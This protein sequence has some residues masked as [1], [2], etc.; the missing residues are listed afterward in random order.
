MVR[1][2]KGECL[3]SIS[4]GTICRL[5]E[6]ACIC[7][8][9][10]LSLGF[11]YGTSSA[12][13]NDTTAGV[14][15]AR[16]EGNDSLLVSVPYNGD[17][18]QNNTVT[19][20]WKLCPDPSYPPANT[21][22]LPHASSPYAVSIPGLSANT[23]YTVQV[24]YL[25]GVVS[26]TNP[27]TLKLNT[28]WDNTM[29]H[30]VNRFPSSAKWGGD[31]GT[32][33]GQYGIIDCET[34]HTR[35]TS[36]IKKIKGAIS[37][38][39]GSF[40]GQ[41]GGQTVN[42]QS[43]TAPNGFGDDTGGHASSNKICEY[44]HSLTS[45]HR[46]NT[47][48]QTNLNH[49]N[50]TD[51]ISCH[52]HSLGFYY[53]TGACDSCHGNPPVADTVGGPSGL[54]NTPATGSATSGKHEFHA[55]QAGRNYGCDVCHYNSAGS[56]S[57]HKDTQISIG[58]VNLLGAYTG[59][60]YDGQTT[61][62]YGSTDAGTVVSKTGTKTCS[63]IYC[64]GSTMSPN[65]GSDTSPAWDNS[66]TAACGTCHGASAANPP[67]RG[68][69]LKH[70][71]LQA[72][73][74]R[75]LPCADCHKDM[76]PGSIPSGM[77]THVD[78][79]SDFAFDT[80]KA[81]VK[82][83][84]AAPA[85]AYTGTAAMMDPYGSCSN[86]YC[87]S[88]AQSGSTGTGSPTY[89]TVAWGGSVT[90]GSCHEDMTGASGSGSHMTHTQT[91]GMSCGTCHPGYTP[92]STNA[93][94]HTNAV[95]NVTIAGTYGGS[96]ATGD[97]APG[98]GY[99]SCSNV[100]CHSSGAAA[101]PTYATS[102]WGTASSGACGTCHGADD[103]TPPA[104]ASHAKHVGS[105]SV[106]KFSCRKC[107]NAT[108]DGTA[109]DSTTK[110][111]IAGYT[112][113]VNQARDVDLNTADPLV[114]S[115]ATDNGSGTCSNIYCHSTGKA[116]IVPTAQLPAEYAGSHYSAVSWSDAGTLG[117]S[118][119][120]GKSQQTGG[121]YEG[122]P[123]YAMAD[124]NAD[125]GTARAN[126][127]LT[128]THNQTSCGVCHYST[129]SDGLTI[130]S[131]THVNAAITV[132][133]D[134]SYN[135]GGTAVYNPDRSC[136]NV[137]CHGTNSGVW[138]AVGTCTDCHEAGAVNISGVHSRHWETAAGNAAA[139][140]NGNASTAGYYQ[141]QCGTCHMGGN[142][143]DGVIGENFA[144]V[145]F[146]IIWAPP[147]YQIN[148]VYTANTGNGNDATDSR[149]QKISTDGQ[150]SNIY[151]HSS[152]IA[153]GAPGPVYADIA[154]NA[155]PQSPDCGVCHAA[156]PATNAH[157]KHVSAYSYGCVECHQGTV[158]NNTTI[159]DK[160]MHVNAV[161]DLAWKSDGRNAD[162]SAYASPDCTNIYCHSQG[163]S[164]AVPYNSAGNAPIAA[165]SWTGGIGTEC[166][167]CHKGDAAAAG[168][169]FMNTYS[170]ASHINNAAVIGN[171]LT[172]DVCHSATVAA[173][174]SRTIG[175]ASN[176][177]NKVINVAFTSL[178]SGSSYSGS[179][180]PGGLA[181]NCN[182]LYCHSIGNTTVPIGQ[183][184]GGAASI[185]SNP[186]WN[187]S[188]IGC[189]GCHGRTTSSGYPDYTSGAAGSSS[190]NSHVKHAGTAGYDCSACHYSVTTN[191]TA[192]NGSATQAHIDKNLQDV[193]FASTYGGNYTG[194]VKTCSTVYCHSNV[195]AAGGNAGPTSYG[196]PVW[197]NNTAMGCG[198]CHTD[199]SITS[200]LTLG[201]HQRHTNA[202][203]SRVPEYQCSMCHGT[204]YTKTTVSYPGP[205][206]NGM[207]DTTFT[208][209][210]AGTVYSQAGSNTPG[211][212]GYGTCSTSLC[213]GRATKNWGT[214]ST[215]DVCEKCHGSAA[216]IAADNGFRD[217]AG[218][219]G[220]VYAGTHRS[221][222][223]A[224][225]NYSDPIHC[226]NCHT[227]PAN[228]N[229][230]GHTSGLPAV[231]TWS[232]LAQGAIATGT[233]TRV[234]SYSGAPART[235]STTYC[236]QQG[237]SNQSPTWGALDYLGGTGCGK[238]HGNPPGFPHPQGQLAL[239]CHG[240]HFHVAT[241]NTS[242]AASYRLIEGIC[243]KRTYPDQ[244]AC[245]TNGGT[246]TP[247]GTNVPGKILHVDGI[248]Q[249]TQDN[250]LGCHSSTGDFALIG[251]HSMHTDNDY[252]LSRS[253]ATGAATGGS[254]TTV[255]DNTQTWSTDEHAGKYVRITSGPNRKQMLLIESNTTDTLTVKTG[256]SFTSAVTNGTTYDI[257]TGKQLS[258]DDYDDP[259][260][261]YQITYDDGFPRYACGFCH[262]S[263][264]SNHRNGIVNLDMD[265]THSLPG[266]V[267]TKNDSTGP[268]FSQTVSGADVT[269][270]AVYCHSNGY[271][272]PVTSKYV[273]KTTPNWYSVSPWAALD[274]CSQC[275]GNSPNTGGTLGSGA[276][277]KHSVGIHFDDTFSGT[278]GKMATA[279]GDGNS[280]TINCNICHSSTVQVWYNDK[281][282]T[283][284]AC[285]NGSTAPL[286]GT[287]AVAPANT[288]HVDGSVDVTFP[289]PLNLKTKAQ[290]RD[291][292]AT[293]PTLNDSWSRSNGYKKLTP[294]VSHDLTRTTPV[295]SAGTCSSTACH[296]AT[297]MQWNQTGPLQCMVCH[298]GLPK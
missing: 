238:C 154:W 121:A 209:Q 108:V 8:F 95:I 254:T 109:A 74:G 120:H 28:T 124:Q 172:C 249:V 53:A 126:S 226:E 26:G 32:Q 223:T 288:N 18:D 202:N 221:H 158:I 266:T 227:E 183:L 219:V 229:D 113:H 149:L 167:G 55:T 273:Y 161:N 56:G 133:F 185:Y 243:S 78:N 260:W 147:G 46:Y 192:I 129:T 40:P 187:G 88:T 157:A 14:V 182:N 289:N 96:Y 138:G 135:L 217:T 29:L 7:F 100:Y 262:P 91:Y 198:S 151:C 248:M 267:K 19:V 233:P 197:G 140:V 70:V 160:T 296:N 102:S 61:A 4:A 25:D 15:S 152:G 170:H 2:H 269:C 16:A 37:A 69:H 144:D 24:T 145:G 115:G 23:C 256:S 141:F 279:H 212:G 244:T 286:K 117:C 104:S 10:V 257:R 43:T 294:T 246:W 201:T 77:G 51:C 94:A 33:T 207:I 35:I 143:P 159:G 174:Q 123:D 166:T 196:S 17:A 66:A 132:N 22:S 75:Q 148:G 181:G 142:H 245:E 93:A 169:L 247:A 36:N 190:A 292:I 9:A 173:G 76:T 239:N 50:N 228:V 103:A 184:P 47:S 153:P 31:W 164:N 110:P 298:I 218:N 105:T 215:L 112:I 92:G 127:H 195:Q 128:E 241:N 82:L 240:C 235:C 211:A 177:A 234:P 203:D 84:G 213:H 134:P 30:N 265:P 297:P 3:R 168:G 250:C 259:G 155:A 130:A 65:G 42:F 208:G 119:C 11:M 189:N 251:Q 283:C 277:V 71:G 176:H 210:A 20:Q 175:T 98:T 89:R 264:S 261:I 57:T 180:V 199:M 263:D 200:D 150:C 258:N 136:S 39:T 220:S 270:V 1:K 224:F 162:G 165:A 255:V 87:H 38:T 242:F 295:Y 81:Y 125:K 63:S 52:P 272:S 27:Q 64:H 280:T 253:F 44:C 171:N 111:G 118:S 274:R 163:R 232:D 285:H 79:R 86:V 214:Y 271:I 137:S 205:H 116:G 252:F 6:K 146:N 216:S 73:G 114:G 191:G 101:S 268:W 278:A 291:D 34:C 139:R 178:N 284:S 60:L 179:G 41:T 45:Y 237:G 21:I 99:S 107:H 275:H 62:N 5:L 290:L 231:L 236:H 156:L 49:N 131:N 287:M 281:N 80:A 194:N 12:A 67:L 206:A 54:A 85:P 293:V 58:F 122:Y 97:H 48:G 204:S 188:G 83:T 230:P 225:H 13:P 186:S 90:C 276:H 106:Y 59:G 72:G 68:S 193:V 282:P 222:L